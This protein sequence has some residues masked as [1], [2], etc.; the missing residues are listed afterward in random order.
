MDLIFTDLDGTLLE[1]F[2]YEWAAAEPA[3][4][5]LRHWR[6]PWVVVTSKTRAEVELWRERLGNEHPFVVE[7][8]GAAFIPAGY[9]PFAAPGGKLRGRYEVLEW[10][11]PYG[12]L[13]RDLDRASQVSH[14]RVRAFHEMSP[15]EV[16]VLCDLPLEQA[17]LA[18]QREYDEPF[19]VLD[20]H[21]AEALASAIGATGRQWT[22][23]GRFWHI[24]GD[25]DKAI[26]VS[27]L[28]GL[29]EQAFGPVRTI[30]LGDGWNDAFFLNSVAVPV[31]IR[32]AQHQE[33]K[34]LV[35]RG[36][37]T[38]RS[39]PAGW[40]EAVLSLLNP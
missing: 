13:I 31:L 16:S 10:G 27:A 35:P 34:A 14:C 21:R 9:F 4:E 25:N 38:D 36:V 33:L 5:R 15:E 29:F 37:V 39:G 26:A 20:P 22:R 8:G 40:N 19:L 32:S 3:I 28:S 2:T 23:G 7:N 17:T 30:G 24:L 6:V 12:Q 11:T 18:Q 1:H